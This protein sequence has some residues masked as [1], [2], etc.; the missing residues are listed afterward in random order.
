MKVNSTSIYAGGSYFDYVNPSVD[1]L[2][3]V[4][5]ALSLSKICRFNGHTLQHYSVAQHSYV[6]S[7]LVPNEYKMEAL[8]HDLH[9]SVIGDMPSPLKKVIPEYS[10]YE[11]KIAGLFR[12][13]F[14][15]PVKISGVVAE[16][17]ELMLFWEKRDIVGR[18]NDDWGESP[19][20]PSGKLWSLHPDRSFELFIKAYGLYSIGEF[21]GNLPQPWG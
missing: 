9:E 17:D 7:L 5:L 18:P 19:M 13:K 21:N 16:I 1:D 10:A 12:S 6:C 4:G 3:V 20:I 2:S 14:G 8:L 11:E 15:L